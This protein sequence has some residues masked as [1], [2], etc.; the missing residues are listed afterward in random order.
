MAHIRLRAD[1]RFFRD[2]IELQ[3]GSRNFLSDDEDY[4][5]VVMFQLHD[6][7]SVELLR[8][9]PPELREREIN[10]YDPERLIDASAPIPPRARSLL[11]SAWGQ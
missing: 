5:D 11:A 9:L 1:W 3:V 2:D 6:D 10:R 7:L 4:G 8:E